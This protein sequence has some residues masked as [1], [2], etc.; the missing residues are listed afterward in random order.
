[1][2]ALHDIFSEYARMRNNGLD[3]K[4]ALAA[5]R[6]Y[7]EPLSKREKEEL[8]QQLRAWEA[9]G[10]DATQTNVSR[11]PAPP[12]ETPAKKESIIKPLVQSGIR[13]LSQTE[14]RQDTS[15][16]VTCPNCSK[17]NREGEIFCYSCGQILSQPAGQFNTR[18]FRDAGSEVSPDFFGPDSLLMLEIRSAKQYF[19][20][21]PQQRSH[22]IVIGRSTDNSAMQ[23]D[24]DLA[25]FQG[26]ETGV[27]RLHLALNYEAADNALQ[28]YDLGSANGSYINGQKLHAKERR[29]LRHGD[30]LRLGRL[31]LR[32]YFRHPGD[33]IS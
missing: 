19:E 20:I 33:E 22:E 2:G 9:G 21:R 29:V 8:A 32:V 15:V 25:D 13:S 18:H 6:A 11:P 10:V 5:L 23:P 24:I 16:W 14:I 28:V 12:E 4:A 3:S 27:S 7:I 31:A 26:A 30:E 1:M 17:K